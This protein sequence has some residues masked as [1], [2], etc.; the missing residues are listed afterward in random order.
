[1][2]NRSVWQLG[3]N[4][5]NAQAVSNNPTP[6]PSH[7]SCGIAVQAGRARAIFGVADA[8][9]GNLLCGLDAGVLAQHR[10]A[11]RATRT[12][13]PAQES[14]VSGSGGAWSRQMS[15]LWF[16]LGVGKSGRSDAVV[17]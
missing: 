9:G 2:R 16:N 11:A 15:R 10:R 1:M 6:D 3:H 13:N 17:I 7:E 12:H 14:T 5:L 4:C 8:Q